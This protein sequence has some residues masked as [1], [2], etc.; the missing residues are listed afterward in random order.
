MVIGAKEKI[1]AK[2][3]HWAYGEVGCNFRKSGQRWFQCEAA[4]EKNLKD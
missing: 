4:L 1:N 2:I 3:G